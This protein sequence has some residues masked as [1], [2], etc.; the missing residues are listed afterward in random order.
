MVMNI[1]DR[2]ETNISSVIIV[3]TDP[4]ATTLNNYRHNFR[5]YK[6]LTVR[7]CNNVSNSLFYV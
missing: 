2:K 6:L 3:S 1:P 7:Q 4:I 5:V